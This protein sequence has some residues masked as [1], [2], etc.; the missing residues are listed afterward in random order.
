MVK[1]SMRVV[2][3]AP[4]GG[5]HAAGLVAVEDRLVHDPVALLEGRLRA[6]EA[7]VQLGARI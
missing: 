1:P 2:S 3:V 6:G 4:W 5:H 7:A